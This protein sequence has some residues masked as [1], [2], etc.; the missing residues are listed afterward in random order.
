MRPI[1][2]KVKKVSLP[3]AVSISYAAQKFSEKLDGVIVTS[4]Q[5]GLLVFTCRIGFGGN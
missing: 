2:I 1:I 5:L 4:P 3:I